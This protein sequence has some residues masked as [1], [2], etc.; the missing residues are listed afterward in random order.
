MEKNKGTLLRPSAETLQARGIYSKE[1]INQ[2]F[3]TWERYCS[4][5]KER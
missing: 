2:E 3:S 1:V 5:L 4:E